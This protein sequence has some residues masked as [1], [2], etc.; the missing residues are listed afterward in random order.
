MTLRVLR[1]LFLMIILMI[2]AILVAQEYRSNRLL[3]IHKVS[4]QSNLDVVPEEKLKKIILS[5]LENKNFLTLDLKTLQ[6]ILQQLPEISSASVRRL[7]PDELWI[8]LIAESMQARWQEK[9]VL[10]EYGEII[11]SKHSLHPSSSLPLFNGPK[12]STIKM[13]DYYQQMATILQSLN[14]RITQIILNAM[15]SVE[16][17][18]DNGLILKLGH[19]SV[20]DKLQKFVKVYP[21]VFEKK[22]ERPLSQKLY[23][24]DLR[25]AHGMAVQKYKIEH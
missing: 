4:I 3:P 1:F 10:N 14:L 23:V 16:I 5:F 21:S 7:W 15:E 9:Y 22:L 2:L 12:H 11:Y 8:T 13:L 17:V 20:V 6:N 25:Y 19:N 24:V 18:L